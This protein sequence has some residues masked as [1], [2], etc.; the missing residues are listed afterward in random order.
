MDPG[1][2]SKNIAWIPSSNIIN[3][4]IY[5][6]ELTPRIVADAFYCGEL[7]VELRL[8]GHIIVLREVVTGNC[9]WRW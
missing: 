8:I 3:I 5:I 9:A 4:V 1:I 7:E 2:A 6:T